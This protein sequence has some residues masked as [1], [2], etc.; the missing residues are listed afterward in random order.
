MFPPI[1]KGSFKVCNDF[2]GKGLGGG[3][4]EQISGDKDLNFLS[5]SLSKLS[6]E[7][8]RLLSS[9]LSSL[10][11]PLETNQFINFSIYFYYIF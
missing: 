6:E 3:N 2:G 1:F 8:H 7:E 10:F 11:A 5:F 9:L 4:F